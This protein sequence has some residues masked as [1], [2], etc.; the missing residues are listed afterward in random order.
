MFTK[1]SQYFHSEEDKDPAFILLT[2]NILIF[3][4]CTNI[5]LLPLVSGLVGG[6]TARNP[7]AFVTLSITLLLAI[8]SLFLIY[9]GSLL[10]AKLIVPL[11]LTLAVTIIAPQ[12]NGLKS[13]AIVGFPVILIISAI[14]LGKRALLLITPAAI[15]GMFVIAYA[16]LSGK[17]N[18]TPAGIEDA[19]IILVLLLS[20]A[21]IIHLLIQR[22]NDNIDRSRISEEKQKQEN[23]KLN[24]LQASLEA[25]ISQRTAELQQANQI[26][27]RRVHQFQAVTEVT[28]I[29]TSIQN[30]ESL[31]PRIAEVISEQFD[32]YHTGIFLLDE[33]KEFAVLRA[34]NSVGGK[35]MLARGHKLPIGQTGIVGFVTA[36]GKPRIALD[37]GADTVFFNNPDLP[38]TR[39]EIALPLRY[40]GEIIGALDV[41]STK[42]SAFS[43]DDVDVLFTL[44]DQ[45]AVAINNTLITEELQ[46][47][48]HE[49]HASIR[50]STLETWQ[51]LRSQKV[52]L[53]LELKESSVVQ[54]ENKLQG[55]HIQE[56]IQKGVT[57]SSNVKEQYRLAI[58]IRLRGNVVGVINIGTR[59][60][61]KLSQ[62]EVEIAESIAERLS[63]AIENANFLQ[64]AQ[65]R[66]EFERITTNITSH[67][68]SSTHIET[69]LKTTAQEL[70]RALDGSDVLVQIE[71]IA[72]ELSSG[73][74]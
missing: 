55:E 17:S 7:L 59:A 15:I 46:I 31:L 72:F 57:V 24:E 70:S 39:S 22:L 10:M 69:I 71:P 47:A 42:A 68:S 28:K 13:S 23:A 1:F 44:A 20:T 53:G 26:N 35:K 52:N 27:E 50:R 30:L 49:A 14:L 4:I 2:R 60:Q 48:L 73:N 29:I 12:G 11:G 61:N 54:L 16:D 8:I 51:I 33:K 3:V 5:A 38:N 56:A 9:R 67:I 36:T 37:V 32:V 18:P 21:G 45:V 64:S 74:E 58:P 63:L 66:A 6:E 62:D 43:Q 40:A 34:S 41:Q 19:V 25:R 65:Y